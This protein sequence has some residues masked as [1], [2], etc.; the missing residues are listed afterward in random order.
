MMSLSIII[1]EV[2][3]VIGSTLTK[4]KS[5]RS[6]VHK[7]PFPLSN[8]QAQ[9]LQLLLLYIHYVQALSERGEKLNDVVETTAR[10]RDHADEFETA[11]K[12]LRE[13]YANRKWWQLQECETTSFHV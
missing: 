13:K 5:C 9:F 1:I 3:Y 4:L 8:V 10:M 6:Y 11:A 2:K 12:A 7:S